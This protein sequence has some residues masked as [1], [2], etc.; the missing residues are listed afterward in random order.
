MSFQH[1][2]V[3]V[4]TVAQLIYTVPPGMEPTQVTIQNLDAAAIFI[5]D[6]AITA[7]GPTIGHRIV[8]NGEHTRLYFGGDQIWAI[9]AAG[10][11]AGQVNLLYMTN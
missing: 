6:A 4:G 5:G 7:S 9:S 8:A 10:T 11:A 1:S 3:T 2:N